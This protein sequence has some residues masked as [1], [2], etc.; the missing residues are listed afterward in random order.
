MT[1]HRLLK[2]VQ[3]ALGLVE[4]NQD[5]IDACAQRIQIRIAKM[6][7]S[8]YRRRP[9]QRAVEFNALEEI[10]STFRTYY[11]NE[12]DRFRVTD[13]WPHAHC[14]IRGNRAWVEMW[15]GQDFEDADEGIEVVEI[16][17]DRHP[18]SIS[19]RERVED[20]LFHRA[21]RRAGKQK[22]E[23]ELTKQAPPKREAV[24]AT[25]KPEPQ[26]P[27]PKQGK[28]TPQRAKANFRG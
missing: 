2:K 1:K 20:I 7:L 14:M 9:A 23:L 16:A 22:P 21:P 5:V 24:T 27:A 28:A 18:K 15:L 25:A 26:K 12:A 10:V 17:I 13:T 11:P 3:T 8:L 19:F 6:D 4:I